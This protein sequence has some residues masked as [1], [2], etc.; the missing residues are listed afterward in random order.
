MLNYRPEQSPR[1]SK[2]Q[3]GHEYCHAVFHSIIS[4]RVYQMQTILSVAG[5]FVSSSVVEVAMKN[6]S[7]ESVGAMSWGHRRLYIN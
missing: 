2:S 7:S 4:Q 3:V 1:A 5:E 6:V